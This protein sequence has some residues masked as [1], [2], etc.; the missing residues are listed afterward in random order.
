MGM[1]VTSLLWAA[2]AAV[3]VVAVTALTGCAP[4]NTPPT[5]LGLNVVD[6][7]DVGRAEA[8]LGHTTGVIGVFRDFVSTPDFPLVEAQAAVDRGSVLLIAWEPWESE[9]GTRVQPDMAPERVLAGDFDVLIDS[10][11][12]DAA[13]FAGPVMIRFAP[14]MNGD[15]RPWSPGVVGGT[16]QDYVNM[17]RYVVTRFQDAGAT[18][19]RWVWNPYVES[20]ESTPMAEMYPGDD[21]VDYVALDGFNWGDVREWG[22]QSYDDIFASSVNRLSAI[23]PD[24]PWLIA[25]V[26]SAPGSE[27]A[28]WTAALLA[29]AHEDG[30]SAV[31]WFEVDKETDWRIT[32]NEE[33]TRAVS[34]LLSE[35]GWL[36][37][38]DPERAW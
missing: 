23:A 24:K 29:R 37:G 4:V 15:W 7:E 31:V 6:W 8:Q 30:A 26:G 28:D 20:G 25:E 14:E 21:Y 19:V 35:S 16:T 27:K 5:V 13:A 10:W 11:A 17:W 2:G 33:T 3:I 36:T 9:R 32:A 22:W 34:L 18:N 1:R 38:A 12:A